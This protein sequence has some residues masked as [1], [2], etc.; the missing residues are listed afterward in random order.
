MANKNFPG[1]N[2]NRLIETDPQII[3]VPL[4]EMGWG[5]RRSIFGHMMGDAKSNNPAQPSAPE[6]TISHVKSR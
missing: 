5:S 1:P 2:I 6:M 3:N 4:D